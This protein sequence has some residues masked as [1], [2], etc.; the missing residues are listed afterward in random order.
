MGASVRLLAR[1]PV[2]STGY[3]AGFA[4]HREMISQNTFGPLFLI[5]NNSSCTFIT[6]FGTL[7]ED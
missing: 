5:F 1:S 6:P 7:E 2:I 3:I 4:E